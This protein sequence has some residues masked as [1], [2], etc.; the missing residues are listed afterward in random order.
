MIPTIALNNGA[1]IPVIGFG[2][3]QI[4]DGSAVEHAVAAA[5]SLGYRHLDCASAYDN[6]TGVGKGIKK[7]RR[8]P[9]RYL[10]HQQSL[11]HRYGLSRNIKRIRKNHSPA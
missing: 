7:R 9:L 11:G 10:Y 6:Q 8:Q 4:P 3:Y 1:T 5:L 2:T